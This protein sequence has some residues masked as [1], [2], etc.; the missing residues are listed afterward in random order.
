MLSS[1]WSGEPRAEGAARAVESMQNSAGQASDD[2]AADARVASTSA[3]HSPLLPPISVSALQPGMAS[4]RSRSAGAP[5]SKPAANS[6]IRARL[7][8]E[9]R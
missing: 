7:V 8:A 9:G 1:S 2:D 3:R 5:V 4:T 6:L